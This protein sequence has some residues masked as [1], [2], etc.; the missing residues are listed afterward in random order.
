MPIKPSPPPLE[1]QH[2]Q[3]TMRPKILNVAAYK[4]VKLENIEQRRAALL[5][6]CNANG[7]RGT[8]LISP[9]GINLF[10]AGSS[11]GV[12]ALLGHL[13][14][15]PA[16]EDL[17]TKNSYSDVQP[18][19]RMLVRLKKEIIAFGVAGVRPEEKTSP[20]LPAAK[21]QAWLDEGRALRLLDVRNEYEVELGSFQ[22]AEHLHISHF[23]EFPKAMEELPEEAKRQPIVMFCT[24][25]IR[26]EKAGPLMEQAGFEQVYQLEGGIL[27]YFEECGGKHFNGACFVFDGRVALDPN[28]KPT[29]DLLCFACQA[30]LSPE[31]VGS[32]KYLFGQWCPN[33]YKTPQIRLQEK[34]HER[35]SQIRQFA[36]AQ[37]GCTPYD[38]LRHIY[39]PGRFAGWRLIDFLNAWHPPTPREQWLQ[40]LAE[41]NIT[42]GNRLATADQTVKEGQCFDQHIAGT[43][44]PPINPLIE[45]LYE[46]ESLV[47]I[48][49]PAPLP[50]HPSGRYNRNSLS[51]I[52]AEAYPRQK[53]R[54][55]H[56]LDANT[57]GVLVLCRT[58]QAA[59]IVQPQFSSGTVQKRY[60]SR[61][62]GH[63]KWQELNCDARIGAEPQQGG[64][65][66]VATADG[67]T[68]CT[69]LS[70]LRRL[71]D[72][73]SL[74][75]A[76]PLTGRTHQ[77]RIHLWHLGHA[78]VGDPL[79]QAGQTY[80][81]A[82][83]LSV[84]EAPMCLHAAQITLCHPE[85]EQRVSFEANLPLWAQVCE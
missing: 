10:V 40:W 47:V 83:T 35:Q 37:P 54:V 43:V 5:E 58:Y 29:G 84:D 81:A 66:S 77:I 30:V 2:S 49:K 32:E 76:K 74:I 46:D 59:R 9:E 13:H 80:G 33:C 70:I 23:R 20:K 16:F 25:G 19:R 6:V 12:Q 34:L 26:C 14:S 79:Y 8:I 69:Q 57:S 21:L 67:L 3:P 17:E 61:V 36:A 60:V 71:P 82:Y 39:V 31:D 73:T 15:D 24:G 44:E 62:H 7:L 4:F 75:E 48:N 63:P 28:L 53:L 45:L 55:A 18:F 11:E 56:R 27:K 41:G 68:A 50:V 38:N 22:G 85:S 42:T 1:L 51:S 72:G 52:L 64:T 78:I 65:R